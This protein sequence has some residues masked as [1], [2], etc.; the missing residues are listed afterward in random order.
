M[1]LFYEQDNFFAAV[2]NSMLTVTDRSKFWGY[3][4]GFIPGNKRLFIRFQ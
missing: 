1:G 4:K 3:D 2:P